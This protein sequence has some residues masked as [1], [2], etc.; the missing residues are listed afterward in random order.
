MQRPVG[1]I[2]KMITAIT[3]AWTRKAVR[4]TAIEIL[5]LFSLALCLPW[6]V[7]MT[8]C[9]RLVEQTG[10]SHFALTASWVSKTQPFLMKWE[11]KKE[12]KKKT[13]AEAGGELLSQLVCG[14]AGSP[15]RWIAAPFRYNGSQNTIS[16]GL[17]SSRRKTRD[18]RERMTWILVVSAPWPSG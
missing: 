17:L 3:L 7:G 2:H 9:C 10:V 12:K 5:L 4:S 6:A 18:H 11:K 15:G 8:V 14:L 16:L 1:H 13:S